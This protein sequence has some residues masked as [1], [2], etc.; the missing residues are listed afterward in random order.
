MGDPRGWEALTQQEAEQAARRRDASFQ[1]RRMV[2]A[3]ALELP[4]EVWDDVNERVASL[5][6][7]L[8]V[9][10][11]ERDQARDALGEA[12]LVIEVLRWQ[13]ADRPYREFS[14]EMRR[15]VVR[16]SDAMRAALSAETE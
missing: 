8:A 15:Q 6:D 3:L 11:R 5:L 16:A 9:A 7:A 2:A 10:V 13:D 12:A 1:T 14:P 4:G